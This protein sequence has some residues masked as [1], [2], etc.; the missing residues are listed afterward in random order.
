MTTIACKVNESEQRINFTK[1]Q[2]LPSGMLVLV[3]QSVPIQAIMTK[4][5]YKSKETLEK[6]RHPLITFMPKA[7]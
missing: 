3:L 5:K 1:V 2:F 7:I 4:A 6:Y